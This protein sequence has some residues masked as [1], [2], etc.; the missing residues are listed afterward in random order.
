MKISTK[1]RYGL[2]ALVDMAVFNGKENSSLGSIAERQNISI[3]YLEQVFSQLRKADIVKSIK[4]AQGG[5]I[6]F[7]KPANIKVGT[8]LRALEGELIITD[9][10]ADENTSGSIPFCIKNIVWD[11]LNNNINAIVDSITLEDLAANYRD[12]N[13]EEM[14]MY[15][16]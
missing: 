6:L 9:E 15:Y 12:L 7:D 3:K 11:K 14:S 16:I 4:G 13:S 2:R 1:G 8:I 5:Y 10:D